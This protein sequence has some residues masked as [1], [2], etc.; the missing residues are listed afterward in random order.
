MTSSLRSSRWNI[1]LTE[2]SLEFYIFVIICST[3]YGSRTV[4]GFMMAM[5]KGRFTCLGSN[6][7][8]YMQ[9]LYFISIRNVMNIY[10]YNHN[11]F[12]SPFVSPL[13]SAFGSAFLTPS[14]FICLKLISLT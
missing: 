6:S 2:S 12:A 1:F 9:E 8:S 11:H 3:F 4:S 5:V 7:A 14:P 13:P 10:K